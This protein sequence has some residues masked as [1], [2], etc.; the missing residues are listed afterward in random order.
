MYVRDGH[1]THWA[2]L[3]GA[4]KG[5]YWLVADSYAPFIKELAWD[6]YFSRAKQYIIKPRDPVNLQTLVRV[7]QGIT[8]LYA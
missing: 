3:V 8:G 7:G 5:R 2:T 4:R 6:Y 1:D